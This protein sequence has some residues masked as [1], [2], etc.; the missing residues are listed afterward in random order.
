MYSDD[1]QFFTEIK[2]EIK[3]VARKEKEKQNKKAFLK[4][5]NA[6]RIAKRTGGDASEFLYTNI[7]DENT[8]FD[9]NHCLKNANL[10]AKAICRKIEE[11]TY[12]VTP[13]I[14]YTKQKPSGGT[15]KIMIFSIPDTAVSNVVFRRARARN[16]KRMS[17]RSFAYHPQ[18]RVSHAVACL[19]N[20]GPFEGKF[21][22]QC[23]FKN[24]FDSIDHEFLRKLLNEPS[25]IDLE[26][27]ERHVIKAF[28]TH[29]Y[30]EK[31]GGG[32]RCHVR[33]RGMPQGASVSMLIA[34]L[35]I[36]ALDH[37]LEIACDHYQRFADD[38]IA[39]CATYD[40]AVAT[41]RII[42]AFA[43]KAGIAL[44]AMKYERIVQISARLARDDD[45]RHAAQSNGAADNVTLVAHLDHVGM[46]FSDL[47]LSWP[48]RKIASLE[49]EI[50]DLTNLHLLHYWRNGPNLDRVG[51][52]FDWD[53]LT[54]VNELRRFIYGSLSEDN[55]RAIL[56][57]ESKI[58]KM[59]GRMR[60]AV[61]L[62]EKEVLQRLDGY[63]LSQVRKA[64]AKRYAL[65]AKHHGTLYRVF[66]RAELRTGTWLSPSAWLGETPPDTR[67]P[68]FMR[69]YHAARKLAARKSD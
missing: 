30:I 64:L 18:K 7:K 11:G 27:R 32:A 39:L 29:A 61:M 44:N 36:D 57:G 33:D 53:L 68:S 12:Q 3:R 42:E 69:A 21:A 25:R 8:H 2:N 38:T 10:I 37:A 31:H 62:D 59:R 24:F 4:K 14:A 15:R 58:T 67:M 43:Q 45:M 47:G 40:E 66:S 6:N 9:A 63:M 26:V 56:S 55:I 17:V 48:R 41:A 50:G 19:R 1:Y 13:A 28:M 34:N 51:S 49:K 46:R 5:T 52:G 22:V 20:A 54:L 60:F 23:D 16:I 35:A 65:I